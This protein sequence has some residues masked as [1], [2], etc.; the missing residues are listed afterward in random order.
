MKGRR[1]QQPALAVLR[2]DQRLGEFGI[3]LGVARSPFHDQPRFG[4][5]EAFEDGAGEI[6]FPGIVRDQIR[7]A[8]GENHARVRIS[9]RQRRRRDDPVGRASNHRR[10]VRGRKIGLDRRPEHDDAVRRAARGIPWRKAL[11]QRIEQQLFRAATARRS[12]AAARQPSPACGRAMQSASPSGWRRRT[13]CRSGNSSATAG[14]RASWRGQKT[15][16]APDNV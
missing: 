13:R 15:R 10:A 6:G 4:D 8:A 12:R 5:A 3:L 7:A 11:L 2:R 1:H 16:E 9:L 14:S